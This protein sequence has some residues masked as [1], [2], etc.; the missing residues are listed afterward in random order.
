MHMGAAL[1]RRVVLVLV[2]GAP[3]KAGIRKQVKKKWK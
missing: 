1:L 2:L 3:V